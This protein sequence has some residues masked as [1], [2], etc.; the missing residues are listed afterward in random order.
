MAEAQ[1]STLQTMDLFLEP[2]LL[3]IERISETSELLWLDTETATGCWFMARVVVL[4]RFIALKAR[5]DPQST[6]SYLPREPVTFFLLGTV[7]NDWLKY[8]FVEGIQERKKIQ[9]H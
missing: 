4:H 2:F 1:G 9:I 6:Y 3:W 7:I 5:K 8:V